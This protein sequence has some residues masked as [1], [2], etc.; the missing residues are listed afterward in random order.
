MAY[1]QSTPSPNRI[2]SF[3]LDDFS[4][5]LN[6]H[7]DKI[8]A[9]EAS[10]LLN[11]AFVDGKLMQKRYG[12]DYHDALEIQD[13]GTPAVAVEVSWLDEW[14]PYNATDV[15]MRA[16][17][18]KIYANTTLIKGDLAGDIS[19]VNHNG[20]YFFGDGNKLYVYGTFPQVVG[21]YLAWTN[22]NNAALIQ[23]GLTAGTYT[24]DAVVTGSVDMVPSTC[25]W[26][27]N[28]LVFDLNGTTITLNASSY[29]NV[30]AIKDAIQACLTA[31][32]NTDVVAGLSANKLTL[33]PASGKAVAIGEAVANRFLLEV[34]TPA[35]G[36]TPLG[37][38]HITGVSRFNLVDVS[39]GTVTYE[40]CTA[41]VNDTYNGANVVPDGVKY[42]ISHN[43]RLVVSGADKDN[44][45]VY[46]TA[47]YND[48]YFPVALPLQLP[49]N[50]DKVVGLHVYD[51][52]VIVGRQ[53][54]IYCIK[55]ETNNPDLG[56]QMFSLDK[57]NTHTGFA[58]HKAV[59]NVNN[60]MFYLGGDGN[61]YALSSTVYDS[62][63][64]LTNIISKQ[65]EL[66]KAPISLTYAD[67]VKSCAVFYENEYHLTVKD[68]TLVYSFE[69]K[70]WTRYNGIDARCYHIADN[71]LLWSNATGRT[72]K[73][74]TD[75]L[76]F[77][78][79]YP[80]YWKS[81]YI[82]CDAA[83][84]YKFFKEL[85]F[86]SHV[87]DTGKSDIDITFEIDYLTINEDVELTNQVSTWGESLWGDLFING[88]Y[89][90]N[91]FVHIGRRGRNL[92]ITINNGKYIVG[93]VATV[94]DLS[95]ISN[96][97][98]GDWAYV[99][100][101]TTFYEYNGSTWDAL[102]NDDVNQAMKVYQIEGDYELRSKR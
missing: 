60:Y 82:D 88:S 78:M 101:T 75:Y 38:P 89:I 9:T 70:A 36:Y 17:N 56:M 54:D 12:Q 33:T 32:A 98:S 65:L 24:V 43:G 94:N 37:S 34:I 50:S 74:A 80:A 41:E 22:N 14:K 64:I 40:P 57:L 90:T 44:D 102:T 8:K 45:N 95:T 23:L 48:Y 27:L 6:N 2:L 55:G 46:L 26:N 72:A 3:V 79:P 10:D 92:R 69:N 35:S 15:L 62:T 11:M 71:V 29:A 1:L 100:G 61:V 93:T 25:K 99:T 7:E 53:E 73:H 96:P 31:D 86:T 39:N 68:E 59:T 42:L 21:D 67:L 85:C 84:N 4:G 87:F 5:G 91:K 19:G 20:N 52:S 51:D 97:V 83:V 16:S 76:D 13:W 30:T 58:N 77:D 18:Q 49:P 28:P 63:K 47:V 66:F 81:K